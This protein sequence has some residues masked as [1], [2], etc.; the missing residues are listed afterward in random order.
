M[1]LVGSQMQAKPSTGTQRTKNSAMQ[2]IFGI[3][4]Q[5]LKSK[6]R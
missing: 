2:S 5:N 4:R 6:P 3:K 1:G